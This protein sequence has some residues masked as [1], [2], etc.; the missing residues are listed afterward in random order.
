VLHKKPWALVRIT[1]IGS[2]AEEAKA[3]KGQKGR[4]TCYIFVQD[5]QILCTRYF[6]MRSSYF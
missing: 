5:L 3:A 2:F 4:A 1:K 6:Y